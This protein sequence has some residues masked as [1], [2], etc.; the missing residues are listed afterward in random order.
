MMAQLVAQA[1]AALQDPALSA[2]VRQFLSELAEYA[3]SRER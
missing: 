2:G 1:K 3:T